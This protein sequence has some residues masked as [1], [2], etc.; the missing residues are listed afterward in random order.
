[1]A[2]DSRF[3]TGNSL[4]ASAYM[5]LH[6]TRAEAVR[7]RFLTGEAVGVTT[8]MVGTASKVEKVFLTWLP[9][10]RRL[11]RTSGKDLPVM[12]STEERAHRWAAVGGGVIRCSS[13]LRGFGATKPSAKGLLAPEESSYGWN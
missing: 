4:L 11:P 8:S 9:F 1:M 12:R 7:K 10:Y 13:Q 2:E 6:Q 3:L 5:L